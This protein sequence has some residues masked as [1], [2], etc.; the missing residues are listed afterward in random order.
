MG[1]ATRPTS[2]GSTY[3]YVSCFGSPGG[4][5]ANTATASPVRA[6]AWGETS[7]WPTWNWMPRDGMAPAQTGCALSGATRAAIPGVSSPTSS[8]TSRLASRRGRRTVLTPPA[9]RPAGPATRCASRPTAPPPT[10]ARRTSALRRELAEIFRIGVLEVG[11][12]RVRVERRRAGLAAG[13]GRLD[14]GQREQGLAREDGR[15]EPQ[16]DGDRVGGARVD[17]NDRV[18]AIDVQLGVVGV[19]L[20]LRD[21]D[22]AEVGAEARDDLLQE[23][24]REGPRELHAGELHRDG[25]RFRGTDPDREHALP[26]PLLQAHD[27]RVGRSIQPE[28]GYPHFDDAVARFQGPKRP[29]ISAVPGSACR[30]RPPSPAASGARSRDPDPEIGRA[31]V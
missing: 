30:S 2:A 27:R 20:H 22:L 21:D 5:G 10:R 15:L 7:P 1:I 16:R 28:V 11:L 3:V 4:S 26:F 12:Q 25:A 29:G 9:A 13:L 24:V 19:V 17:L 8:S 14:R 31:H 18:A 23:V 6:T